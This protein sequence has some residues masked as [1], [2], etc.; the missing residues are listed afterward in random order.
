MTAKI[1]KI[2]FYP[3]ATILTVLSLQSW[4]TQPIAFSVVLTMMAVS[5]WSLPFLGV[6]ADVAR[7]IVFWISFTLL[8]LGLGWI[9]M[10]SRN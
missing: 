9:Y 2:L 3:V 7:K 8:L 1:E 4:T 10:W 6:K 5:L